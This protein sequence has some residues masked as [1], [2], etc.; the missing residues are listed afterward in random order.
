MNFDRKKLLQVGNLIGVILTVII[1][2]LANALPLNGKGTGELSDQYP[3]LFVPAGLIFAIWGVIYVFLF[4]FGFYQAKDLFK[5][6]KEDLPVV[7]KINYWFL[8]ASAANIL[9]IFMWHYEFI[10]LSLLA[11]LILLGSLIMIYLKLNIGRSELSGKAKWC[12][13]VNFSIYLGWITVATIANVTAVLVSASWDG[14]G[15]SEPI[16]TIIVIVVATLITGLVIFLRKDV[17]YSLV[18]LWAFLGIII[19]RLDPVQ[20]PHLEIVITTIVCSV[21]I[22]GLLLLIL[23]RKKE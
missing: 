9:W 15:L 14:F 11:M 13:N 19:K 1:N 16:W 4:A 10:V 18:V 8:L 5:K 22:V 21:V 6:E 23:I 12:I 20:I 3:N 2:V 7:D 17:A